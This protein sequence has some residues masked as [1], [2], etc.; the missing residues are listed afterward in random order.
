[1]RAVVQRVSQ[2]KVS[3]AGETTGQI[4]KGILLLLGVGKNDRDQDLQYILEK[5]I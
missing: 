1:M 4:D 5:T 2:A 3:V